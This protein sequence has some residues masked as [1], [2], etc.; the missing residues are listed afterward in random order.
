MEINERR[1]AP[2]FNV[3]LEASA[4]MQGNYVCAIKVFNISSSGLQFSIPQSE[5]PNLLPNDGHANRLSPI[6]IE[7]SL[8]LEIDP[9]KEQPVSK[10]I[11]GI[12]YIQR[13][14]LAHCA[15]GCRF[16][17]FVGNANNR[18]ER[19]LNLMA[20]QIPDD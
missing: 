8:N 18:L 7:I 12:V 10:V 15:V 2:R 5:L 13:N 6:S 9:Q 14:S 19:Y 20:S 16:E 11:C 17:T 3:S 4:E 1:Q